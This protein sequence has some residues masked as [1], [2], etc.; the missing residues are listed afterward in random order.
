MDKKLISVAVPVYNEQDNL[1]LLYERLTRVMLQ[2]DGYDYEIVFYDDGSTD[3]SRSVIEELCRSD[4]K[5]KAVF[6]KRNFGYSKNVFYSVQQSKGDAVIL[7]HADMQNPPEE[8]PKFIKEWE[9]GSQV[10][11]GV[12]YKSRENRLMFIIRSFFYLILNI[13]FGLH[14]VPHATEFG[15]FDKSFVD[16]LKSVKTNRPFLRGL[17]MQYAKDPAYVQ[18]IQDRRKA[19][20]SWFNFSKLYSFAIDGVV[21]YSRILPRR[22]IIA[23]FI[24]AILTVLEYF[25]FCLPRIIKAG[26]YLTFSN[27]TFIHAAVFSLFVLLATVSIFAEYI[28]AA[29]DNSETKPLVVEE[30][31][32]NY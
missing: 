6:F 3:D 31:R 23:S 22:L 7:I 9:K 12:K 8:I 13:V 11:M 14:L 16:V 27:A 10:V 17:V 2:L 29:N 28:I 26:R 19:G 15:L 18:Y 1:R 25:I 32:I 30:K 24:G 20:K 21:G 5:V 4:S